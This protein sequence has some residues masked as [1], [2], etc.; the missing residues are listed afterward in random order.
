VPGSVPSD[1]SA[2]W[3]SEI[4]SGGIDL[5]VELV[6]KKADA[7]SR[8][9]P[10]WR[11]ECGKL[12]GQFDCV[13][14]PPARQSRIGCRS[15]TDSITSCRPP[16]GTPPIQATRGRRAPPGWGRR[17]RVAAAPR[18]ATK[19][20]EIVAPPSGTAC[21]KKISRRAL[22]S[23]GRHRI[24][25]EPP[26]RVLSSPRRSRMSSEHRREVIVLSFQERPATDE[27]LGRSPSSCRDRS[28]SPK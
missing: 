17:A 11:I 16:G 18:P 10:D 19:E 25:R 5:P 6:V 28:D 1:E 2:P 27:G 24:P 13:G 15:S 9:T 7:I 26:G 8:D 14:R 23:A 12:L 3:L 22:Q 4:V 21:V 20:L